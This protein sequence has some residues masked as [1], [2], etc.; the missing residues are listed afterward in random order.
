MCT[1]NKTIRFKNCN[2]YFANFYATRPVHLFLH[3]FVL[4]RSANNA[5]LGSGRNPIL[6]SYKLYW[7]FPPPPSSIVLSVPPALVAFIYGNVWTREKCL[8]PGKI[9]V[10]MN[11]VGM[12][13]VPARPT[14]RPTNGT[15]FEEKLQ[16]NRQYRRHLVSTRC[17]VSETDDFDHDTPC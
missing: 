13:V 10:F 8:L 2:A 3:F 9:S 14:D 17:N 15:Q 1:L 5:P 7:V 4:W 11:N 6:P 16:R 12:Q